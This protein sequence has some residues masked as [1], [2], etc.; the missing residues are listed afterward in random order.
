MVSAKTSGCL[1]QNSGIQNEKMAS[2]PAWL[3][4]WMFGFASTMRVCGHLDVKIGFGCQP[5]HPK[6]WMSN[7]NIQ[8]S[9]RHP[10]LYS[11]GFLTSKNKHPKHPHAYARMRARIYM[12]IIYPVGIYIISNVNSLDVKV[13][14]RRFLGSGCLVNAS[15]Y[16][17]RVRSLPNI[18]AKVR[19]LRIA[20]KRISM[21]QG[22]VG[23]AL[24][25]F[26][27]T[28]G[29][30]SHVETR[31]GGGPN[32]GF[33]GIYLKVI[34]KQVPRRRRFLLCEA[35]KFLFHANTRAVE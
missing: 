2:K 9:G 22:V 19:G 20:L 3:S 12:D 5:K 23:Y 1:D 32:V 21:L 18:H 29:E 35:K 13:N 7:A 10:T 16:T 4:V 11:C 6:V 27:P 30:I 8:K 34:A 33:K 17:L 31:L 28:E 24:M 14:I 26:K 15:R 25:H